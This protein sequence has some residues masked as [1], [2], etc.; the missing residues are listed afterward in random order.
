M[1][2]GAR[3]RARPGDPT[4]FANQRGDIVTGWLAR[5]AVTIF[6][7]AVVCFDAFSI[8]VAH[9]SAIDDA[10]RT[11]L[12][13]SAAWFANSHDVAA[14]EK[15]AAASAASHGERLVPGSLAVQP[16]GTVDVAIR[17]TAPTVLLRH[18]GPLRNWAVVTAHGEARYSGP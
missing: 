7:A 3:A 13:A 2:V 12:A 11:A 14:A 16:D 5:V 6:A 18:I 15:A 1:V 8:G 4:S 17:K 10:D 9:L